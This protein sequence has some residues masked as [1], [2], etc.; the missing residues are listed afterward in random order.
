MKL[1]RYQIKEEE[2]PALYRMLSKIIGLDN[3]LKLAE[4][5]GGDAIYFPKLSNLSPVIKSRNKKIIKEF[6]G[7]NARALGRKYGL[8]ARRIY[9]IVK[10]NDPSG[11]IGSH[12][13]RAAAKIIGG[14]SQG[15]EQSTD[16]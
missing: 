2:L 4:E 12:P 11:H 3:V 7:H 9:G 16:F 8:T 1:D 10:E 5:I 14:E 13:G 6:N 15:K